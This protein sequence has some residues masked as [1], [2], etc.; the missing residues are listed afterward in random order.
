MI[1]NFY[2][3]K[4]FVTT[5]VG[6]KIASIFFQKGGFSQKRLNHDFVA[7]KFH[8]KEG[9]DGVATKTRIF[10]SNINLFV[11]KAK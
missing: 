8:E 10:V 5:R 2:F 11:L 4:L 7:Y 9:I 6:L 3:N 1:Y